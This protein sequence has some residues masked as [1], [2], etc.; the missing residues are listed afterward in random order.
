MIRSYLET[1]PTH[2]WVNAIEDCAEQVVED[3]DN[4]SDPAI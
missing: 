2:R 3:L 4:P 1:N